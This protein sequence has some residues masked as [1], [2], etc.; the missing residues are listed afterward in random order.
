M[1]C[2]RTADIFF[3][4]V[5]RPLSLIFLLAAEAPQSWECVVAVLLVHSRFI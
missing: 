1:R 5:Q 3:K 4:A 2:R